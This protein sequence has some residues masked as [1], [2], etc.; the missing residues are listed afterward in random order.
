M[1]KN[2]IIN[3]VL[4]IAVIILFILQFTGKKCS[5]KDAIGI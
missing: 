1:N 4:G 2:Y 5:S 3:G